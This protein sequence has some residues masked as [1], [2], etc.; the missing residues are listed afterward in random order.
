MTSVDLGTGEDEVLRAWLAACQGWTR[1]I[2]DLTEKRDHAIEL[3]KQRMG[4]ADQAVIDGKPAISWAWSKPGQRLDRQA[5][6]KCYGAETI[7][8]FLVDNT[9]ARPFKMLDTW[10]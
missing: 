6:E 9:P 5:L 10:P 8:L 3:I 4:D 1:Q 2:A 7:A